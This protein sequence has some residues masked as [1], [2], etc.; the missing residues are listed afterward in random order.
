MKEFL[1][2]LA[3]F[4]QQSGQ[5]CILDPLLKNCKEICLEKNTSSIVSQTLRWRFLDFRQKVSPGLSK[6]HFSCPEENCE[7]W[8]RKK[9]VI[10]ANSEKRANFFLE[11]SQTFSSSLSKLLRSSRSEKNIVEKFLFF[12][13]T[14]FVS[15]LSNNLSKISGCSTN[16]FHQVCQTCLLS[17][18]TLPCKLDLLSKNFY[19]TRF[20]ES[21]ATTI[22]LS[23]FF[24]QW[25]RQNCGLVS[26][27]HFRGKIFWKKFLNVF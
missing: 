24:F 25:G 15:I 13:K 2:L 5:N 4:S 1:R 6:L 20:P 19:L 14:H 21:A 9:D 12:E 26:R 10:L 16:F 18:R 22:G 11:F 3:R 23:T 8:S 17:R 7:D 27:T